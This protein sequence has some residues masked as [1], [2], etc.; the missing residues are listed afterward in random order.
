MK[1]LITGGLGFIFSHVTEKL[2]DD[3]HDIT[4]ID[5]LLDGSNHQLIPE[6]KKKGIKVIKKTID[7]F[8]NSADTDYDIIIHAAAE[9]N[10]DKSIKNTFPF[11]ENIHS[12]I[13]ILGLARL[14]KDLKAFY[15]ISTDEVHGST[16]KY[17]DGSVTNPQNPYSA[18]KMSCENFALAYKNTYNLP[19]QIIRMCNVI[20]KRQDDTKLIPRAIKLIR[21]NEPVPIYDDGTATREY[22]DVRNVCDFFSNLITNLEIDKEI[23]CDFKNITNK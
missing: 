6:F 23:C 3:G 16:V 19:V 7:L 10:V 18:S 11:V 4:V 15:M 9:S 8:F 21:N 1:I 5:G 2:N 20:G 14:Q 17:A 13:A 12:T 22:I